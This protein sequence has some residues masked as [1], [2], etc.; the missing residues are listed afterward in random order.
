MLGYRHMTPVMYI[1]RDGNFPI[2]ISLAIIFGIG[3]LS[4]IA[5][6]L[7]GDLSTSAMTGEWSF[8]SWETYAGSAIGYGIAAW[9][10]PYN[11]TL[12]LAV[13]SGLSTF[14]GMSLEKA[15]GSKN[16]S[17]DEIALWSG[18]SAGFGALMGHATK[19]LRISRITSGRGSFQHVMR[20]QFTNMIRHG[21]NISFKTAAKSFVALTVSRQITGGFSTGMRRAA[22]EWWEYF[23]YG[24]REGLG[25]V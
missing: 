18:V 3:A 20:T 16:R 11:P 7:I 5:G 15:T 2:L 25:W 13:G 14:A 9:I 17:W 4:G 1:D 21:Y 24:D 10:M 22:Q 19:G 6:T 23:I 12:A 8:S